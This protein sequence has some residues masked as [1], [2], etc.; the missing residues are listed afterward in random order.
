MNTSDLLLFFVIIE[1]KCDSIYMHLK[2]VTKPYKK[3][4]FDDNRN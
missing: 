2:L 3:N 1:N 4:H